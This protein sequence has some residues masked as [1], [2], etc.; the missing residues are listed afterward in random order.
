ME[1]ATDPGLPDVGLVPIHDHAQG[2]ASGR[3]TVRSAADSD[4]AAWTAYVD[5]APDATIYHAWAWRGILA[6]AFGHRPHYLVAQRGGRIVGVLP[7]ARVRT[8]LFGDALVSLPFCPYAGPVADDADATRALDAAA[9]DLGRA[10]GV[11]HLEY[12][13]LRAGDRDWPRQDGLYVLFRKP[14]SAD[15]EANLNAIPRKQRAMVRK[16]IKFGL[17]CGPGTVDEFFEL[18]ADN[19]HRHGTPP[20]AKR[21]FQTQLDALGPAADIL[22]VRDTTGRA[23]S[24]VLSLWHRDEVLPMHA[25]DLR[26]ARDLAANDFK[27]WALMR[28][29]VDRGA[30][31]FN[32]GRSKV[33][34]GPYDFKRNWGFEPQP[35]VYEY[36]LFK[37]DAIPQHNPLNPKYQLMIRTWRRLPRF[38]VDRVG[39]VL[40][41]GLG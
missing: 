5:A 4:A 25:G 7:L 27:Y 36:R 6:A 18:H 34:T 13:G 15:H 9:V 2:H 31:V 40:V 24:G 21:F 29:A 20:H 35:L 41:R 1:R 37:G 38:V 10:L 23:V 30:R 3:V 28:R 19:V 22:V 33:G 32:Y 14:V 16:G 26:A 17:T 39:P 11:Q 12:R 8:M